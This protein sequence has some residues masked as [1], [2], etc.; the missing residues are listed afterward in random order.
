MPILPIKHI[1]H[2][3]KQFSIYGPYVTEGLRSHV[4]RTPGLSCSEVKKKKINCFNLHT[5]HIFEKQDWFFISI[6]T[7]ILSNN[8]FICNYAS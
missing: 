1:G 4:V 8:Y 2:L 3:E 6:K 7:S 5:F